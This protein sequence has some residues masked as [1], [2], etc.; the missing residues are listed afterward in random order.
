MYPQFLNVSFLIC[1]LLSLTV[2]NA[3]SEC[4]MTYPGD[5]AFSEV[6]VREVAAVMHGIENLAGVL[7]IHA[8]GQMYMVSYGY[9]STSNPDFDDQVYK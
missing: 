6:E 5:S 7:A 8:Y 3:G 4:T 2:V 9:T 1:L